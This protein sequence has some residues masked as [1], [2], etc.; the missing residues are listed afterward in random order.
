MKKLAVIVI[1]F[2]SILVYAC[3]HTPPE[4]VPQQP[5]GVGSGN[6]GNGTGGGQGSNLVCFE[7]EI[8][9]L[10][11]SNCAKSGCHDAASNKKGYIL[12][13]YDNL[14][15]KD[16]KTEKDNIQSYKPE[17]SKLY[18]VLFETG[19]DKMPPPPDP[20]LTTIQKNLIGRW[21]KEGATNTTN[22]NT[23]CDL[24]QFKFAANIQP[25]LQNYCTG[26]HSGATPPN[27]INLTNYN[28]V[29][30][31]ALSGLLYGVVAHLP[32]YVP[33]PKGTGKLSACEIE[34]IKKWIEGGAPNN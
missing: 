18:E 25:I 15:K 30:P 33:M 11:Q 31:V 14:F 9:P 20:D 28:A 22:C 23:T 21:I 12:D 24:T 6:G 10:F 19:D 8:L 29:L 1:F 32:G 17:D 2:S 27:G 13:S 4:V 16:N 34:E 5:G 3:R 26:C 7:S